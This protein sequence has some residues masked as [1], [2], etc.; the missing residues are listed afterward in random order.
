MYIC[1]QRFLNESFVDNILDKQD[2]ICL[3][4]IK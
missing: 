3:P 2:L 4:M 1:D